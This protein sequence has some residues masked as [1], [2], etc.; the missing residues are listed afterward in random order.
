MSEPKIEFW[1]RDSSDSVLPQEIEV[2]SYNIFFD[3]PIKDYKDKAFIEKDKIKKAVFKKIVEK[4]IEEK[5]KD[6]KVYTILFTPLLNY[7][8]K[9]LLH[10]RTDELLPG[11]DGLPIEDQDAD[12]CAKHCLKPKHSYIDWVNTKDKRMKLSIARAIYDNSWPIETEE[13]KEIKKKIQMIIQ[14]TQ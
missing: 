4:L 14:N 13:D 6:K 7:E 2:E 8:I 3:K 5:E 11:C 12:V 1:N 9:N 10:L